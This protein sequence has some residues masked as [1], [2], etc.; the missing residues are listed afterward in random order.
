[1]KTQQLWINQIK[2]MCICLVV[3][4]HS[5]I[6]FYPHILGQLQGN[7]VY[8]AKLWIYGNAYLAPFRMPVFFF[9]SGYLVTRYIEQVGW[10]GCVNKRVWNILWVLVLW[11]VLQW[12]LISHINQ[13][14]PAGM[15]HDPRANAA[16][17]NTPG[18]FAFS[19]ITASTSLW[20]L[21]ALVL[22]FI[23]C[24]LL[25]RYRE[26]VF[27]LLIAVSIAINF[28]P[29]P[30]WGMNSVIRNMPY[31]AMGAWFGGQLVTFMKG[32]RLTQ[33]P[34]LLCAAL[35]L[36]GV[37]YLRNINLPLSMLSIL[38][39]M[40][41]FFLSEQ[42]WGSRP[43]SL[44]NIIGSNTIAIYTTHR[45]LIEAMSLFI[46]GL[47]NLQRLAPGVQMLLLLGYPLISLGMCTLFGLLMRRLS[48]GLTGDL[49]FTPPRNLV[50]ER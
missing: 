48:R 19:M 20:Y 22:Y 37:L 12:L 5:V 13:W 49:L 23:G 7:A 44:F 36:A 1:M 2:G 8:L 40:K 43:N 3:I 17:A 16:Y 26:V 25:H 29:T 21:Y 45:I 50:S 6:T 46:I 24:K 18:Q 27:P 38:F 30:F 9:I 39:I 11:G 28:L 4:Y 32:W 34:L 15:E 41:L 10:R 47:F 33:R 31:Y 42:R 14:L 35:A